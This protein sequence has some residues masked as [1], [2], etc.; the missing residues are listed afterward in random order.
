MTVFDTALGVREEMH[1]VD[2]DAPVSLR[3]IGFRKG[4]RF[5]RPENFGMMKF[6][7]KTGWLGQRVNPGLRA[8]VE[9]DVVVDVSGGDSFT[10]MY[11]DDRIHNIAGIKELVLD[12]GRPLLLLPQTYGPF[13][14]SLERASRIVRRSAACFA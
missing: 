6:V 8:I 4:R 14:Q 11:P 2:D 7:A 13:D 10:D 1:R 12:Q 9:S 3:F 5:Y